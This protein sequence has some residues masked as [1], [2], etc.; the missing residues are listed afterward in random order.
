[1]D[2]PLEILRA[3]YYHIFMQ[4]THQEINCGVKIRLILHNILQCSI[5][6]SFINPVDMEGEGV[7]QMSILLHKPYLVKCPFFDIH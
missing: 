2:G 1:M 5:W 4:Y 7:S 6:G 3:E